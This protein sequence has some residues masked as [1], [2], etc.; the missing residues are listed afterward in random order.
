MMDEEQYR[1][2]KYF[3]EDVEK[4]FEE[5]GVTRAILLIRGKPPAVPGDSQSLTF[6]GLY[7]SPS[8]VN[9]S[10]FSEREAFNE[11]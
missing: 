2:R 4:L 6:P 9:R 1:D 8:N 10:K 5:F 7:E 11:Q 3:T